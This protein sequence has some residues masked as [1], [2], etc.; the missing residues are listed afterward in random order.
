MAA[1]NNAST[2]LAQRLGS[3][4]LFP[5]N[6]DFQ[7]V[8]GVNLLLQDIQILLLTNTGERL[9]R[10]SYGG[11]LRAQTWENIDTAAINGTNA[12]QAALAKF[13]PRIQVLSV[14]NT[15]NRNTGL[16]T[17]VINFIILTTDT[18]VNLVFP[19]RTGTALSQ[20]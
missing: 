13:E 14:T 17:F 4:A 2:S 7:I 9:F 3:D 6:G 10:P 11:N 15:I 16:I 20:A 1:I 18:A 12:I 5:I 19:F 8:N